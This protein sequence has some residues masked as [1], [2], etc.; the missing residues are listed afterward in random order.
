MLGGPKIEAKT[1][2]KSSVI[3]GIGEQSPIPT[4]KPALLP[5]LFTA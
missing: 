2:P 4:S 3:V 5:D 1:L